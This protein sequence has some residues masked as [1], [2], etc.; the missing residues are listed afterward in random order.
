MVSR[1]P[2]AH[3]A[4]FRNQEKLAGLLA[5]RFTLQ[6]RLAAVPSRSV[7][8]GVMTRIVAGEQ[9]ARAS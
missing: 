3:N 2:W 9:A 6:V 8:D 7:R 1:G 4:P 5:S